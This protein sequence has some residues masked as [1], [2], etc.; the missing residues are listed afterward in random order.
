VPDVVEIPPRVAAAIAA[1]VVVAVDI[2][3]VV[4]E[5]VQPHV[6]V[7]VVFVVVVRVVCLSPGNNALPTEAMSISATYRILY[8]TMA[9]NMQTD[10]V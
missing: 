7:F 3:V 9:V 4:V 6:V 2:V 5:L 10:T 8:Q 1:V